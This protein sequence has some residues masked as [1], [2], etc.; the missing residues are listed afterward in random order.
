MKENR[1]YQLLN[2]TLD[3]SVYFSAYVVVDD[4]WNGFALPYF[5]LEQGKCLCD[6]LNA[7]QNDEWEVVN[8]TD[9]IIATPI[10]SKSEAYSFIQNFPNKF[11][12]QGYYVTA[13]GEK[14][15]PENIKLEIH[16][17]ESEH[18][19]SKAVYDEASDAFIIQELLEEDEIEPV[20]YS[21]EDI[22]VAGKTIHV[23][24][25]GTG[26]WIWSVATRLN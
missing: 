8:L 16:P 7:V 1:K 25:I 10:V 3:D 26:S 18:E 9:G 19:K 23:Y 24:P 6:Y 22:S 17:A 4:E 12:E 2:V 5:T 11:K 13:S 15:K 14:I 20:K 21:V